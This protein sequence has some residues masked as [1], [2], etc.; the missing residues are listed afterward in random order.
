MLGQRVDIRRLIRISMSTLSGLDF[1]LEAVW[2]QG[3][4]LSRG[5]IQ[6][7]LHVYEMAVVT[8]WRIDWK[9]QRGGREA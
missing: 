6:L 3:T 1:S 9:S 4:C 8:A 7:N 5:G 2:S